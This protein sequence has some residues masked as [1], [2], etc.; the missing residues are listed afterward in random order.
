MYQTSNSAE[1][2][3]TEPAKGW[4]Y[5]GLDGLLT[6]GCMWVARAQYEYGSGDPLAI[7][8]LEPLDTGEVLDAYGLDCEHLFMT[9]RAS[10]LRHPSSMLAGTLSD[11]HS[12]DDVSDRSA[13][14]A[15]VSVLTRRA[16]I[17][18][19]ATR[20]LRSELR[21]LEVDNAGMVKMQSVSAR[22][23][24]VAVCIMAEVLY[25]ASH[26]GKW[27]WLA[28]DGSRRQ[29]RQTDR[30]LRPAWKA[31]LESET[32][33]YM[34]WNWSG[35][36][37]LSRFLEERYPGRGIDWTAAINAVKSGEGELPR[38]P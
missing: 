24:S 37:P 21:T 19:G 12:G 8:V 27:R 20:G 4:P 2:E 11:P 32:A 9:E 28:S 18:S 17:V 29:Q 33:E 13:V 26:D 6:E 14:M 10:W 15:A 5:G 7:E 35:I 25:H 34:R 38:L 31:F 3:Q 30:A 36:E 1:A 22:L 23:G 16:A